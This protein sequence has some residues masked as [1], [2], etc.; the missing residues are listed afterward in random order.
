MPSSLA[1][2]RA[3]ILVFGVGCSGCFVCLL[4]ALCDGF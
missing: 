1:A 2:L 3:C 4:F